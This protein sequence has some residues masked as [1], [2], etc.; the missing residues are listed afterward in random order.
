M[1]YLLTFQRESAHCAA[2]IG[3]RGARSRADEFNRGNSGVMV[4]NATDLRDDQSNAQVPG[5]IG[6]KVA[7][8]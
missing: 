2:A 7:G 4:R 6:E 1:N 8:W 5:P 3:C